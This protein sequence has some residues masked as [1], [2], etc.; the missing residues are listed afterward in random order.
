LGFF[1]GKGKGL[2]LLS[3]FLVSVIAI[4][5]LYTLILGQILR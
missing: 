4:I 3:E 1:K 2:S 5:S